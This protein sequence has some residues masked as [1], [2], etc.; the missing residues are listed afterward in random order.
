MQ[1]FSTAENVKP[2]NIVCVNVRSSN[3]NFNSLLGI[4]QSANVEY[5]ILIVTETWENENSQNLY[6]IPDFDSVSLHRPLGKL[7]GGIKIYYRDTLDVV[8]YEKLSGLFDTHES[9]FVKVNASNCL[10]LLI[11]SFYRPP[12]KSM[13]SFINYMED[14]VLCDPVVVNC[15]CLLT[16][17]FNINIDES[18]DLPNINRVY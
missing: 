11:G 8:K 5:D 4:L 17:D 2:F 16:G 9:L 15:K 12:H 6:S 10:S 7:G 1:N 13:R 14:N 3:K 18:V